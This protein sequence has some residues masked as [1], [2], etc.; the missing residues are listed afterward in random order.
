VSEEEAEKVLRFKERK[1][2]RA[3][4]LWHSGSVEAIRTALTWLLKRQWQPDRDGR[5][6]WCF[7]YQHPSVRDFL[8]SSRFEGPARSGVEK[9]H[10]WIARYY[11]SQSKTAGWRETARYGRCYLVRHLLQAKTNKATTRAV[12][13]LT[14]AEF[15]QATLGDEPL[16]AAP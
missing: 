15:L 9:M 5:P 14:S 13:L 12:E 2:G 4:R 7:Q 3:T 10:F 16:E 11:L 1:E 8:L 6:Q